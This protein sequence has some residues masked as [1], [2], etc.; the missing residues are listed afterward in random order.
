MCGFCKKNFFRETSYIVTQYRGN[1][2]CNVVEIS[3]LGG[4][5]N[6]DK[7]FYAYLK[8]KKQNRNKNRI[9]KK[10]IYVALAEASNSRRYPT[11]NSLHGRVLI[12]V[13]FFVCV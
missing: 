10:K 11:L 13:F 5:K 8:T 4:N 7:I 9:K 12:V 6:I 3:R 2:R 1:L